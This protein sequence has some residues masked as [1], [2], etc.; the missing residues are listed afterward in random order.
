MAKDVGLGFKRHVCACVCVLQGSVWGGCVWCVCAVCCVL[1][2]CVC[3][4]VCVCAR[5][6]LCIRYT[7]LGVGRVHAEVGR[8]ELQG[9]YK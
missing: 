6:M 4:R 2:V 5:P 7:R 8:V 9:D 1:C 3:V